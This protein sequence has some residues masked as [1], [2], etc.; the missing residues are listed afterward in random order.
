MAPVLKLPVEAS[1]LALGFRDHISIFYGPPG[2]GKTTFVNGLSNSTLFLSTDRGTRTMKARRME[3]HSY[4]DFLRVLD[5]LEKPG[6]PK[7]EL[8][9]VDHVDDLC[10][11]AEAHVCSELGIESLADAGYGKGWKG[12]KDAIGQIIIRLKRLGTGLV[13]IAHEAIKTVKLNGVESDRI[14]PD[15]SKSAWKL[16]IP[17][18][19]I[20][21]YCGSKPFKDPTTGLRVEKRILDCDT[22]ESLYVKDRSNRQKPKAGWEL[23][24]PGPFLKSFEKAE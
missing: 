16:L 12:Y 22:R 3:C 21:L 5:L 13:F 8:V 20:V 19:D 9:C 18:A 23:L 17:L 2:I 4:G 10:M 24:L 15:M 6:A 7:Y 14:M 1:A 11:M